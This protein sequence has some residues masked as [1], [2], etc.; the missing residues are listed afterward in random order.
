MPPSSNCCT[1]CRMR[2]WR[3]WKKKHQVPKRQRS[4]TT[5][6]WR[7]CEPQRPLADPLHLAAD[8]VLSRR[9]HRP[10]LAR[11]PGSRAVRG[12]IHLWKGRAAHV[13]MHQSCRE[14]VTGSDGIRHMDPITRV[15]IQPR[16]TDE[17]TTAAAARDADQ[18]QMV[19]FHE[20]IRRSDFVAMIESE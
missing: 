2:R 4:R 8:P 3:D 15:F 1:P 14:G 11:H 12:F 6:R 16:L 10:N 18:F 9:R 13:F 17:Q 19:Q 5:E 7:A 20:S